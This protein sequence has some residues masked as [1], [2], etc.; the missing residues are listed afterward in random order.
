MS[1]C[2]SGYNGQ[3]MGARIASVFVLLALSALGSFFPL[4]ASKCE[5]LCIPK[6]VFFVSKYF[7]SGVIIATAFIH[8]L[9]EAQANFASPCLDSSWDDYPWSSAFALMGAFVMF[10]IE[11]FVQKGMQ[12]RHQMEREQTD[13]EQQVAKAGVV[14][15]KE[16]EIEEQEVE[17]T[18]S[19][20]DF[21]EKQSKFNKLLNLFLLEFGIVFHSVFVGLSLAIAGREFPT[22]FIAISF[23]QFFE[24]LGIGSRFASTVWPEKLRSLPWIFALVF[25][26]TTPIGIAAGLGVRTIYSS[27][28]TSSLLVVGIFDSFCAGLIMYNCA[29]ELMARD[30][31]EDEE[32]QNCRF[33]KIVVGY[34]CLVAGTIA[35]AVIGRWA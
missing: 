20:E 32:F 23:H 3:Y 24:G 29:V 10:T 1:S 22:L 30:F 27:D 14:G 26:L 15:T 2:N 33:R 8:L 28:S 9:G 25:S 34:L 35:M 12:H 21:L 5:C 4:V 7:G 19:E 11:L 13:E 16:E 31:L 18:S 17:S 6:K